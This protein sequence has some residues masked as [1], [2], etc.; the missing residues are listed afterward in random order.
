MPT[1]EINGANIYYQAYGEERPGQ[2]PILLIHGSTLTGQDDWGLV[3][4]L[5]ARRWRVIVPDCRGHGQSS[6]PGHSYSFKELA[7]DA[8]ALIRALGYE[9]AHVIGY[10]NGGNVALVTLLEHPAVIQT[11]IPQAANAYVSPDLIEKEPA[12]FDPD[13]VAREAPDWMNDMIRRHAPTHGPNYWRDLLR[14]TVDEIIREPNYT[15]EQLA[16]VNKPVLVIQGAQDRVNAPSRHAQFIAQ[17]I[18]YAEAWIPEGAGHTVH[19][20]KLLEWIT[21]VED[22]LTRRGSPA[23][24]ALHRLKRDRYADEREG[25]F[26]VQAAQ[27]SGQTRLSGRVLTEAQHRAAAE[28]VQSAGA[29][30]TTDELTVLLKRETPWALIN[31]AVTDLRRQPRSLAE[32]VSQGL[33]GET[34][35]ILDEAGDWSLVRLEHDGYVG[36]VH[37]VALHRCTLQEAQSYQAACR[38]RVAADLLPAWGQPQPG[39]AQPASRLTGKL[40]FGVLVSVE[41]EQ[42]NQAAV[43]LPDG[44]LWWVARAGLLPLGNCPCPDPQ[45]IAQTLALI[46][47]FIG[48][49]YLWGGR[50]PFGYDC[51]GLAGIFYAFMGVTIPRDAD[52]QYR[53][54]IPVA[55]PAQPGDLLYFGELDSSSSSRFASITHVGISL[56]GEEIIHAN[57]AAWGVSYNSL[58]PDG[59]LYRAWLRDHLAGIRRFA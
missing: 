4:P 22:F 18:P 2:A 13:R 3:A 34:A 54:G 44:R 53:A 26:E 14:L 56:G 30:I 25:L 46:Q 15:P 38:W 36:W 20:E 8:A 12:I 45:G 29:S 11:C 19:A 51:S 59:P 42:D 6:N 28:A 49:P 31:R 17:H 32:R 33:L 1:I 7:A 48:V 39:P 24:E 50:S 40:P 47:R 16:Q 35:R 55:G 58:N 43:R 41:Q 21:K 57:G 23:G 52:Q 10:S 5:L 27:T 9:R 37:T